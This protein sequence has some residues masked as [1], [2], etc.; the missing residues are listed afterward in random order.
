MPSPSCAS[1]TLTD[2]MTTPLPKVYGYKL[3]SEALGGVCIKVSI[4]FPDKLEYRAAFNGAI[5][6]LGKWFQW[7]HTQADYQNIPDLNVEVAQVWSGVLAAATWEECMEF[8]EHMIY[9]LTTDDD[10]KA[11]FADFIAQ[12]PTGTTYPKNQELPPGVTGG[13][14]TI[15]NPDCDPDI[16][17]AQCVGFVQTANRMIEDFLETWETYTNPGET[18]SAIV[19]A[20][21]FVGEAADIIGVDAI[22]DYANSIVDAIKENY[23]ADYSLEYENA[24]ACEIFCASKDSCVV[25][26]DEMVTIMNNRLSGQLTLTNGIELLLSL[27]DAD[28]TGI[29]V[30]DLYLCAFFNMLKLANLVLPVTWGIESYLRVTRTFNTPNDDWELLC[31]D[32]PPPP[33]EHC[34]SFITEHVNWNVAFSIGTWSTGGFAPITDGD[35]FSLYVHRTAFA[36]GPLEKLVFKFTSPVTNM[37]L[38]ADNGTSPRTYT[39]TPVTELEFSAATIPGWTNMDTN[40]GFFLQTTATS[41]LTGS[42]R[43]TEACLYPAS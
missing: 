22:A 20:I 30:A 37:T 1:I 24:L 27:I 43:L 5:N 36:L 14:I 21:P 18:I 10:V 4:E 41:G 13:N 33:D 2:A 42:T 15:P 17:W 19:L 16:L 28:I 23:D 32:C 38:S 29:N 12:H 9:C 3:P 35:H 40:Q 11:A 7:E 8:C 25:T 26:L 6:M 34:E 39:G 31:T